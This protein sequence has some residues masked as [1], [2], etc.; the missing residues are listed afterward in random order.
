MN[1]SC[2][3]RWAVF[4]LTGF[5]PGM[6]HA[7]QIPVEY[8]VVAA[9]PL[10][11]ILLALILGWL[12]GSWKTAALHAGG[13]ALWVLLFILASFYITNDYLLWLPLLLYGAHASLILSLV[14]VRLLGRLF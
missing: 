11:A 8:A 14:V 7:Q 1:G 4:L 2:D 9:S 13:V 6:A 3:S 12:S 10:L 5:I